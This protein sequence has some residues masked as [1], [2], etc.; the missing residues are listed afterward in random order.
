[1]KIKCLGL[2]SIDGTKVYATRMKI[3]DIFIVTGINKMMVEAESKDTTCGITND[4]I[5]NW[6]PVNLSLRGL[7]E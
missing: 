3:G 2:C 5:Q 1:M 7:L 6:E 4:T